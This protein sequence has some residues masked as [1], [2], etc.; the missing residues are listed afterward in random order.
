MY[1]Y[2][3]RVTATY[4]S[5]SAKPVIMHEH[6]KHLQIHYLRL[7]P[8]PKKFAVGTDKSHRTRQTRDYIKLTSPI[9]RMC[10]TRRRMVIGRCEG[11]EHGVIGG[12]GASSKQRKH[13]P[14]C[15]YH[16]S[17]VFLLLSSQ[18]NTTIRTQRVK[19]SRQ[20]SR[21]TAVS[22]AVVCSLFWLSLF[23]CLFV[24]LSLSVRLLFLEQ[25][26]SIIQRQRCY[27]PASAA[28]SLLI[29]IILAACSQPAEQD[30][31]IEFAAVTSTNT[32]THT[33][34]KT[35]IGSTAEHQ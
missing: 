24:Y 13:W 4:V 22:T 3:Q 30:N 17:M 2:L 8:V 7:A 14:V 9:I 33:Y 27:G 23:L 10:R 28:P 6:S 5:L 12:S 32:H 26:I 15:R 19:L 31:D 21:A 34:T 20:S 29:V 1:I 25:A 16:Y 18:H 35:L 11:N